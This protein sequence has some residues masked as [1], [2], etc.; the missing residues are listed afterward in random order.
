MGGRLPGDGD[1]GAALIF[2]VRACLQ[3]NSANQCVRHGSRPFIYSSNPSNLI[4]FAGVVAHGSSSN[5]MSPSTLACPVVFK[6]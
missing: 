4:T 1:G 2:V 6:S 5:A 3:R